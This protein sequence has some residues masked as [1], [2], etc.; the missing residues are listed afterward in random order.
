MTTIPQLLAQ[1]K[2]NGH[3]V[4]TDGPQPE[5]AIVALEGA[6]GVRLPPSYRAFLAQFGHMA[7]YDC[8]ISGIIRGARCRAAVARFM[9][10][11][12]GS[13]RS[14]TYQTISRSFS[15]TKMRPTAWTHAVRLRRASS[16]WCAMSCIP[17]TRARSRPTSTTGC[18]ASFSKAGRGTRLANRCSGPTECSVVALSFASLSPCLCG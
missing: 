12:S 11:R 4:W 1:V 6:I 18:A 14:G 5:A 8:T 17:S 10:T 2:A 7:I 16:L 15:L 3:E 9:A 13:V